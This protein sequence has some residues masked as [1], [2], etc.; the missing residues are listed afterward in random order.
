MQKQMGGMMQQME[1]IKSGSGGMMGKMMRSMFGKDGP[2]EEDMQKMSESMKMGG[3]IPGM[4]MSAG[5]FR[6][7]NMGKPQKKKNKKIRLR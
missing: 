5:G 1:K 6:M 4:G 2:S 3:G 7:P